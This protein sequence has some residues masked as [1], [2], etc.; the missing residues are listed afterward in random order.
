MLSIA[1]IYDGKHIFPIDTIDEKRK[2]K[3]IITFVEEL[4]IT[5]IEDTALR[6]F[7][8]N[9]ASLEFW[10]NNEADIYQDYLQKSKIK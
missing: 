8:T 4:S 3:V 1:G 9:N 7:G 5:E 6:N 2:F 10:N